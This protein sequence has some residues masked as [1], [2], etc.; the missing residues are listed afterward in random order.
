M[1]FD[2]HLHTTFSTDSKMKIEEV[3]ERCNSLNIGAII[4]EH[5]DLNFPRPNE[6]IFDAE[7]YLEEYE[8]YRSDKLLLGFEMGMRLDCIKENKALTEKHNFDYVIGS[9]HLVN[10][11]DIYGAELYRNRSKTEAYEEYL[12]YVYDCVKQYDFFD[13]LGHIDYISRYSIYEDRE[14]YYNEF[15]ERIDRILKVLVEKEKAIEINTRRLGDKKAVANLIDIYKRYNDLGGKIAVFGSDSH[16]V[17]GIG[18]NFDTGK[19]I[20]EAANLRLAYFKNRRVSL[21]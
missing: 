19:A 20:A 1:M 14:I 6:F 3:I 16:N 10:N 21:I 9:I 5:M 4:T 18:S 11:I 15:S 17:N 8:K 7:K 13:C 2:C 12:D